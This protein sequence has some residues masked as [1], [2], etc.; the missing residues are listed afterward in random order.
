[1][2]DNM[3]GSGMRTLVIV[4]DECPQL[5]LRV[6][7]LIAQRS[8]VPEA[9]SCR[10]N[11]GELIIHITIAAASDHLFSVIVAKIWEIIGVYSLETMA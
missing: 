7:G 1:M 9:F 11:N 10:R 8:I 6:L 4:A 5:P 3:S 2:G